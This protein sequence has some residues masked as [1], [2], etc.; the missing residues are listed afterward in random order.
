MNTKVTKPMYLQ[1]REKAASV[2]DFFLAFTTQ[3]KVPTFKLPDKS[4][5]VDRS[6]WDNYFGPFAGRAYFY[7]DETPININT[8]NTTRLQMIP[9]ITYDTATA[10]CQK[11]PFSS[12]EDVQT[13]LE[14]RKLRKT[15]LEKFKY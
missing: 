8:A 4:G 14:G 11:R 12:I 9:G 15:A 10:I 2:Q 5:I 3:K 1:E 13:R 6:N 7:C